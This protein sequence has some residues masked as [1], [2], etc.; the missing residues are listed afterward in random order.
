MTRSRH[1]A[2]LVV[3]VALLGLTARNAGADLAG[4]PVLPAD[5]IW[6]APVDTL[7]VD[8]RSSQ[9]TST[10]IGRNVGLHPDFGPALGRRADRH[11]VHHGAGRPAPGAGHLRLRR[12]ERSGPVSRSRPTRR[13]RAARAATATA[14]SSS[15]TATRCV[16]YELFA[17][18]PQPGGGWHAG[19]GAVFDLRS[20]ALR[21]DGLDVGRR[22]G[23]ADP[24]RAGALRRGRG[25]GDPP[26]P[27]LHRA[28]DPAGATSG[29]PA[30]SRRTN[31]SLNV[32]PM[33]SG[34]GSRRRSTSRGFPPQVQVI[35]RALKTLRH[36]RSPTTGAPGTSAAPPTP[37]GTTTPWCRRC[38]R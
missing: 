4:C 15:S 1:L 30:T 34:S 24:A 37:A 28:G 5:N 7:P 2:G 9:P 16:L 10:R 17:A 35:L 23:A 25:R 38:A 27:A 29:R 21:P 19:S 11:P 18:Y 13:S 14:T 3:A 36:D 8:P 20:N 31:T 12:R 32:P 6:N 22:R 26:R 33:G